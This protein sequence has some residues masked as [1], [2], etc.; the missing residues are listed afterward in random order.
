MTEGITTYRTCDTCKIEK[1]WTL[2]HWPE[3]KGKPRPPRCRTCQRDYKR[4]FDKRAVKERVA[5]RTQQAAS[6]TGPVTP[7]ASGGA[8]STSRDALPGELP[9]RQLDAAKA[10]REGAIVLNRQAQ[11]ILATLM[12]YVDDPTHPHHEW[13]LKL[14]AERLLPKKL[15]EDLGAKDAGILAGEGQSRPSVTIIV[16]PATIAPAPADPLLAAVVVEGTSQR[17][18]EGAK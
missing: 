5:A 2:E 17:V 1:P 9:L 7:P 16:Q 4:L 10:L 11:T 3:Q 18:D 6:L 8:V 14:V 15:Y 13:A 12:F